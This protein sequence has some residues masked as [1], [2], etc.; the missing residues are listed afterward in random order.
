MTTKIPMWRCVLVAINTPEL[1]KGFDRLRGTN[2]SQ[3]GSELELAIDESSGRLEHDFN[4]FVE[5]V[6]DVIYEKQLWFWTKEWQ[7]I[8][9]EANADIRAGNV[10]GPFSLDEMKAHFEQWK[11]DNPGWAEIPEIGGNDAKSKG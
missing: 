1:V 8:E 4:E 10:Y 5:F 7:E 11:K 2:L 6:R 3:V 9:A